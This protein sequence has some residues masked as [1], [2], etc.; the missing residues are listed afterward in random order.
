MNFSQALDA[1]K[2]G[3][4]LRRVGWNGPDQFVFLVAGSNFI[5]NREPLLSILGEG[6]EVTYLPHI[7][8][9]TQQGTIV[10]WLASQGDMMAEDWETV[11]N[12]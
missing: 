1:I 3:K 12:L 5:T 8:I 4:R 10:P 7:D 6:V 2:Q 9:R 11:I